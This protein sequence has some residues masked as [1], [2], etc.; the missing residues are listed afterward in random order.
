MNTYTYDFVYYIHILSL[1][2]KTV[3]PFVDF[4]IIFIYVPII[5]A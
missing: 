3:Y 2:F 1:V 5:T 4:N